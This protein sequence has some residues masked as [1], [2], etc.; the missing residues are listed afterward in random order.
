MR[1]TVCGFPRLWR[2]RVAGDRWVCL[3]KLDLQRAVGNVDDRSAEVDRRAHSNRQRH[4]DFA[5]VALPAVDVARD[6]V[7]SCRSR[8]DD[9]SRAR[10][11]PGRRLSWCSRLHGRSFFRRYSLVAIAYTAGFV[12]LFGG[13]RLLRAAWFP[14]VL[15]WFVNP[16]PHFFNRYIDLPLQ[17]AS[18]MVA[19]S[20]AHALGQPLTPDQLS[21]MFTPKFGM[22]IAPGCNGIRG[23]VT[24]GFIA[25]IAGYLYRLRVAS[26]VAAYVGRSAA[27][28]RVQLRA[29]LRARVLLRHRAAASMAAKSCRDGRLHPGSMPVLRCDPASVRGFAALESST[30]SSAAAIAGCPSRSL[31][32]RSRGHDRWR[33]CVAF[34]AADRA[35]QR[36][37]RT[38]NAAAPSAGPAANQRS[39]S[40]P[41]SGRVQATARVERITRDRGW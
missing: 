33:R 13:V 21:L 32:A 6:L 23:A 38:S 5:R 41:A 29:A 35:G 30:R 36:E 24:M 31:R 4:F 15:M 2:R 26:M 22:F 27:R 20:F 8:R 40:F 19:R 1:Q 17:H 25:L 37:L 3:H 9:R 12:L 34:A 16:V 14:V 11:R 39:V 18:A 7:G 10:A 28:I